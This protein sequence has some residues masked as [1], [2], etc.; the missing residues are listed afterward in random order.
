MSDEFMRQRAVQLSRLQSQRL[1]S[2]R[3]IF[4]SV[5]GAFSMHSAAYRDEYDVF[6]KNFGNR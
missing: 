1:H 2:Q 6:S 4:H 3:D 5:M